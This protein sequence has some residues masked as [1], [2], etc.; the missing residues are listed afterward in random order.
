MATKRQRRTRTVANTIS[1][2]NGAD[3][4]LP[5]SWISRKDTSK[6]ERVCFGENILSCYLEVGEEQEENKLCPKA[7]HVECV[8]L[9]C[10]ALT[11]LTYIPSGVLRVRGDCAC[12]VEYQNNNVIDTENLLPMFFI[13]CDEINLPVSIHPSRISVAMIIVICFNS[14]DYS[15][16]SV[17]GN[18]C[19]LSKAYYNAILS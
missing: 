8:S 10:G 12:T 11:V 3:Q 2:P 19:C 1:W 18:T 5:L 4:R 15:R 16:G 13:R 14:I 6:C 17:N 7:E 9:E